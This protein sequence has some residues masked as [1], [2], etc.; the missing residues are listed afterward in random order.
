M[1]KLVFCGRLPHSFCYSLCFMVCGALR[2][3]L[4]AFISGLG[5]ACYKT[6]RDQKGSVWATFISRRKGESVLT[7]LA[8]HRSHT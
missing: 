2:L 4:Y 1:Q 3:C 6:W 8:V 7:S 5:L